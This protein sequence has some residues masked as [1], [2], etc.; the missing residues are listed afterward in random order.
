[1][2]TIPVI[3]GFSQQFKEDIIGEL[4]ID[5][6]FLDDLNTFIEQYQKHNDKLPEIELA[7][8]FK[9]K[10]QDKENWGIQNAVIKF[11]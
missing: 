11:K 2:K 4:K 8:S 6:E 10:G 9:T 5:K 3:R 1:M 7:Y